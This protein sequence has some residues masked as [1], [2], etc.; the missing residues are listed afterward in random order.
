MAIVRRWDPWRDLMAMHTELNRLFERTFSPEQQ[1]VRPAGWT[2][3]VDMFEKD[4]AI[5]V[6]AELPGIKA[7]DIDISIV[8]NNLLIK[9]ERKLK[10]EIKEENY[11]RLEQS[12]GSF[13]RAIQLPVKVNADDVSAD[14]NNGVLEINLPKAEEVKP[15]QIKVRTEDEK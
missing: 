10:E 12:Y 5:V 8:E 9:G 13:E 15:K 14:F 4:N 1:G 2:P 3:A 6:H 11:Y 7:E